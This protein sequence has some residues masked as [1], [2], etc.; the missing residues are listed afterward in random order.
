MQSADGERPLGL[1]PSLIARRLRGPKG[2]LFH[3]GAGIRCF[4]AGCEALG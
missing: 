2:P 1:K 3:G 4:V